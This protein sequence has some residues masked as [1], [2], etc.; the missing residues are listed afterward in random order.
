MAVIFVVQKLHHL[1]HHNKFIK[2]TNHQGLE[3]SF[4]KLKPIE[5]ITKW[6]YLFQEDEFT[7]KGQ[8]KKIWKC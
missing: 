2:L 4:W 5:R 3:Y 8:M 1:V 7:I 6:I